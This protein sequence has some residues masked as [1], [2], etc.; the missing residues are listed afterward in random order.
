MESR[1]FKMT[2]IRIPPIRPCYVIVEALTYPFD[3]LSLSL[4]LFVIY[5]LSFV[6]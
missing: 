5:Y 3:M 2:F 4:L 1:K 6:F